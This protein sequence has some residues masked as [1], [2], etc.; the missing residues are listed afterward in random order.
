LSTF[1]KKYEKITPDFKIEVSLAGKR[2]LEESFTGRSQMV[3]AEESLSKLEPGKIVP[4]KITKKGDGKLYYQT[5]M[6][7]A[8]KKELMPRDEGFGVVKS[9]TG[10]DEKPMDSIHAGTLAVVTLQVIL[11]QESLYVVVDDPLPAGFEAVN[12]VFRT[13]SEEQQRRMEEM[14]RSNGRRRQRG[15]MSRRDGARRWWQGFN[16][17]EMHNDRVLLFADSLAPGIHTHRYLVRAL[18][19]GTFSAPGT[20][21]EEMYEPEV[22]G[23]SGELTIKIV[24]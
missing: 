22:F 2:L 19:Y 20:K 6:T 14:P 12:P 4:L 11:P 16:H 18:T 24:K 5:R 15:E 13:E 23:R 17:I 3:Q 1:Y 8:P 10:L 9:I 21:I 7:Y